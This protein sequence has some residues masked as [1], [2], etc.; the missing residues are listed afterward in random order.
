[1]Q[2][3][4]TVEQY[5][6]Q[7]CATKFMPTSSC[8]NSMNGQLDYPKKKNGRRLLIVEFL[9]ENYSISNR[10]PGFV[11]NTDLQGLHQMHCWD[12]KCGRKRAE[13]FTNGKQLI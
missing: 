12:I 8:A 7:L 4:G 1:M 9:T 3:I 2:T 5:K 6:N 13:E 11:S 10:S